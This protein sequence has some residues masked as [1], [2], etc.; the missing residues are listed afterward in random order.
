MTDLVSEFQYRTKN[1]P[2]LTYD[3]A[4]ARLTGFLDWMRDEPQLASILERL[5]SE[6][7][8]KE[9]IGEPARR[10]TPP[11]A[12]TPMEVAS[13]GL[14]FMEK[15]E[16]GVA[17]HD[18]A[19]NYGVSPG[20]GTNKLQD[21]FQALYNRYIV[22]AIEHI[23]RVLQQENPKT[24]EPTSLSDAYPLE[25]TESLAKFM[26]DHPDRRRTAFIM[27]QFGTTDSHTKIVEA[28]KA[29]LSTYG[30]TALRA[31]EKEYHDD[32]FPN[33]LTYLH[34]CGFGIAVFERLVE[35]DFN[36]NVSLEV[37]YMRA[38]KK[39]CCLLKD[40]TLNAP[41]T[42]LVGK[43]YKSFDPQNPIESIPSQLKKWLDDKG[44]LA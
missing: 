23:F 1:F 21:Y 44:L 29:A 34:G 30:I 7:N 11:N 22:P 13:V 15:I 5:K 24:P 14:F 40:Q 35:D 4:P 8:V 28:I 41:S 31:D 37:G 10:R 17:P 9:L 36:P 33:V 39:P 26:S 3:E 43:L 32:L 27:M 12:G 18:L 16:E 42:D 20:F 25:I 6:T 2:E 19:M 38:I